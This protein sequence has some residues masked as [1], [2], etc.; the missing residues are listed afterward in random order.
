MNQAQDRSN[1]EHPFLLRLKAETA[2]A[3]A[4]I[5]TTPL[6]ARLF[7]PD[8]RLAEYARLLWAMHS[9]VSQLELRTALFAKALP[10]YGLRKKTPEAGG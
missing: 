7:E 1:A 2:T 4:E 3:H 6:L 9:Y 5:E 8:Y 10:Q